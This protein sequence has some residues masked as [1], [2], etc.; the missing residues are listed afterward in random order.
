MSA[1]DVSGNTHPV[2]EI[3]SK[4][5]LCPY[6]VDMLFGTV[7]KV[8][9]PLGVLQTQ[10]FLRI[11]CSDNSSFCTPL[12]WPSTVHFFYPHYGTNTFISSER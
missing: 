2:E 8:P 12:C 7:S 4:A 1:D 5:W 10:Q 9:M 3:L 11:F 6:G